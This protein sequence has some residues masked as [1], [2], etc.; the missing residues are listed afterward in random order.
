M[1]KILVT[2][3]AGYIG[4]HATL[5]LLDAG[6]EVVVLD[7]LSSGLREAV[8]PGVPL[9]QGDVADAALVGRT[10][11]E[12]G[13]QAVMHFAASLIVPESVKK[14]LLYWRNNVGGVLGMLEGCAAA[15]VRHVVFSSTAAVY[16]IPETVP[17]AED[18]PTRPINPYGASKL[19]AER[20]IADAA[21]AH[22]LGYAV[23]RYFN[24][25]GADPQGR[26]GQRTKNATHIIKVACEAALGIRPVVEVYGGDY[27]T[28]DGTGVRDY[29]HVTDLA[30]AHVAALGHLLAGGESLTLNCGYGRGYSV[31]QVLAAVQRAF[32]AE[33]P[34]R[35]GGRRPGDPPELVAQVARIR[36]RLGWVPQRDDLDLIVSSALAWERQMLAASEA[37]SASA[38]VTESLAYSGRR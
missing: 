5:A 20:L 13:A 7:N 27:P 18:T 10:L 3:G 6:Y 21:Q 33:I 9:I 34:V 17:V 23:L 2:G 19:A 28:P 38:G 8:P 12:H 26:A 4:S 37:S 35:M 11:R 22:G 30:E 14:P 16:G 1:S 32:N 15:G 24:V 29:V 31:N 25:A 36:D